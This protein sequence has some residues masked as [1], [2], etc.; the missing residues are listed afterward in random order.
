MLFKSLLIQLS[1]QIWNRKSCS[2]RW[3][4]ALISLCRWFMMLVC[5]FEVM[6]PYSFILTHDAHII[7]RRFVGNK[8]LI[9]LTL[10]DR[11]VIACTLWVENSAQFRR[12]YKTLVADCFYDSWSL[13]Q[14][15]TFGTSYSSGAGT[16]SAYGLRFSCQYWQKDVTTLIL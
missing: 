2:A 11:R 9:E 13:A 6:R 4:V 14:G 12:P 15:Y 3:F 7:F 16:I 1:D 8:S 5:F 10:A